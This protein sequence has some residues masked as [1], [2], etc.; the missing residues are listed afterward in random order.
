MD[1]LID[2]ATAAP[3]FSAHNAEVKAVW[4]AFHARRPTRV[5]MILGLNARYLICE[6]GAN[7]LGV[8]F[9][10]YSEDP[11]TMFH[12]QLRFQYWTRHHLPQ[13]AEMGVPERWSVF[14]DFQNYYEA[15]W[16]GCPVEYRDDQVPDAAP[17]YAETPERILERGI[18]DP[19]SGIMGR[20]LEYYERMRELAGSTEFAGR[21]V[22]A[23]QPYT[24]LLTD[25]PM[26]VACAMFT[27]GVVC[28]MMASDPQRLQR[29]LDFI[30]EATV[31]RIAA[32][33]QRFEVPYPHDHYGFADDSIALISTRAYR[34]HILPLHRRL[35]ETFGT[36]V[37]RT[38]HLCGDATRHFPI[39]R[40][41]LGVVSF[42]TGYPVDFGALR[43]ALGPDILI[44]G[45]P[46]APFLVE[47]SPEAVCEETH[48][49]LQSGVME[50]GRFILREGNN[51]SP[52]T[53]VAN[54]QAMYDAVHEYGRYDEEGKPC[55]KS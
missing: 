30:T 54:I 33:K 12:A 3:D 15:A 39:I 8:D 2:S 38:I 53:P 16:F 9:R 41:E 34:E 36:R 19:F 5:P 47:A 49:I 22:E 45:G 6:R 11:D 26:T 1:E 35:F 31:Q 27:P 43:T 13:D 42:D 7:S 29:L 44:H 55:I 10:S 46:R 25:G 20:A 48:R 28:E 23:A 17:V 14:V 50:G 18:P 32:W 24:G 4:D 37:G 21:P 52:G 51:L 40:D